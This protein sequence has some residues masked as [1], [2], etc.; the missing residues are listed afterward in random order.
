M[1]TVVVSLAS[2]TLKGS[3]TLETFG[4]AFMGRIQALTASYTLLSQGNWVDVSLREVLMGEIKPFLARGGANFIIDGPPVR[5]A[6]QGALTFGMAVHELATNAAKYGA[7]STPDGIVRVTWRFD[8]TATP[9]KF[10][11]TWAEENGPEIT[12]P[13]KRGFG[14]TLIERGFAHELSGE[15]SIAF[16]TG[17]I[18]A[19]LSAPLGESIY[20]PLNPAARS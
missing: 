15:A 17:G 18:R 4:A 13:S 19:I 1:L 7:L 20:A 11:L 8:Q 14:M 3:D 2:Q 9:P 16:S 10:V 5:L 12:G 6:P